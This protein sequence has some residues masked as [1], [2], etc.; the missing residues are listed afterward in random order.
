[1]PKVSL[2][3]TI[4]LMIVTL[5][6]GLGAGYSL[7]PQYAQTMYE[8]N[9]MGLGAADRWVDLRYINA[10]IAHHRG[11]VLVAQQ[12][13]KSSKRTEIVA[14]AKEIQTNE[15]VLIKNLYT[16][17]KQLYNDTAPVTDPV[18]PHLGTADE[19]F[20]LRFIN[21]V[22]AHHL[23]GIEMTKEIRSKSSRNEVLNDADAV[24]NFLTGSLKMLKGWRSE[25][26]EVN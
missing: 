6:V 2:F 3:L 17:K 24:E 16:L 13:E 8:K 11:A 4:S 14:L 21:V 25:W 22:I 1:M 9:S 7:T 5:I 12:A 23:A 26:Y 19:K 15:P 10:M 20:D 18:I